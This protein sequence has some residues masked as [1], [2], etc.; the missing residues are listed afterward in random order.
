MRSAVRAARRARI[1]RIGTGNHGAVP[2]LGTAR[3]VSLCVGN[4]A[5]IA[6]TR[7]AARAQACSATPRMHLGRL[8]RLSVHPT[9]LT[10]ATRMHHRGNARSSVIVVQKPNL[11]CNSS[12][13]QDGITVC[14]L[15]AAR[16]LVSS[17]ISRILTL[18]SAKLRIHVGVRIGPAKRWDLL[19]R[20]LPRRA[21]WY[22]RGRSHNAANQV[23]VA[24]SRGAAL[25]WTCSATRRTSTGLSACSRAL[26]GRILKTTMKHGLARSWGFG[27]TVSQPRALHLY[28]AFPSCAPRAM[29]WA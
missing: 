8:A 19:R 12:A 4:M 2:R 27:A 6:S 14:L 3:L 10:K 17:A 21:E 25:V 16:C 7:I 1:Q 22:R 28:S 9:V 18:V 13:R 5:R 23:K 26:R 20:L 29:R 11:G 24:K 15:D